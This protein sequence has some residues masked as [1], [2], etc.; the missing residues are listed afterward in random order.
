MAWLNDFLGL[1]RSAAEVEE[2]AFPPVIGVDK[3]QFSFVYTHK[4]WLA[5]REV[6]HHITGDIAVGVGSA[7]STTQKWSILMNNVKCDWTLKSLPE[8]YLFFNCI[9]R[10]EFYV[11]ER[12]NLLETLYPIS[13]SRFL[14]EKKK[15][16]SEHVTD[17]K[18][19][20]NL[21]HFFDR[22]LSNERFLQ[23]I[24]PHNPVI[25]TLINAMLAANLHNSQPGSDQISEP[26]HIPG[27]FGNAAI[28]PINACWLYKQ[29]KRSDADLTWLR[30]GGL[31]EPLYKKQNLSPW[32]ATLNDNSDI[33]KKLTI[34]F[35]EQYRFKPRQKLNVAQLSYAD[36]YL[37]TII[38]PGWYKEEEVII[39]AVSEEVANG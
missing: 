30:I 23:K 20:H 13:Q 15:D 19:A 16:V 8:I 9:K 24:I 7:D 25:K 32:L 6:S 17:G 26:Y 34:D 10:I 18:Q 28:L 3:Q 27:Y 31:D 2:E 12:G 4:H 21:K 14:K 33:G 35:A 37:E 39:Q 5:G 1:G 11:D 38:A 36:S 29:P 22:N